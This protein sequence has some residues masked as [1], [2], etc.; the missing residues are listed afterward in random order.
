MVPTVLNIPTFCSIHKHN[1]LD[2]IDATCQ[3]L[4]CARCR[5]HD[6]ADHDVEDLDVA[7]DA[8]TEH[9]HH[10]KNELLKLQT[11]QKTH[12]QSIRQE[13][14]YTDRTHDTLKENIGHTFQTLRSLLDQRESELMTD[15]ENLTKETKA[16]QRT[17]LTTT[18]EDWE[19]CRDVSDYIDKVLHYAPKLH[20]LELESRVG[21]RARSCLKDVRSQSRAVTSAFLNTNRLSELK[22]NISVF[23]AIT[24]NVGDAEPF[25]DKDTQTLD[26]YMAD[27]D[28]KHKMEIAELKT[29]MD[30]EEKR[31]ESYRL[32]TDKLNGDISSL[33]SLIAEKENIEKRLSK[34]LDVLLGVARECGIHL[35]KPGTVDRSVVLKL[36]RRCS[37]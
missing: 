37:S 36:T 19:T 12:M 4:I 32:L 33:K 10:Q 13:I 18:E 21:N 29:K 31:S 2:F 6:H 17:L 26:D 9:F 1:S 16:T 11:R 14:K 20:I 8:V 22:S 28:R 30:S 3:K 15:L 27:L 34:N 35:L 23:G 24:T 25:K 7:A 5:L